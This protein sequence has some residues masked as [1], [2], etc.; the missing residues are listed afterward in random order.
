[1]GT[2]DMACTGTQNETQIPPNSIY[3]ILAKRK[4]DYPMYPLQIQFQQFDTNTEGSRQWT[5]ILNG[6]MS[7]R[8][9]RQS[10][11]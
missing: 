3:R 5:E 4:G 7:H 6:T 8:G 11:L 9:N 2:W 10:D 1:M